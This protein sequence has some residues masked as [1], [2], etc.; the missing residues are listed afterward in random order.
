MD[1]S[2]K[3]PSPTMGQADDEK[4]SR[5]DG[6]ITAPSLVSNEKCSEEEV[7]IDPDPQ[8]TRHIFDKQKVCKY[9]HN[10]A[11]VTMVT[12]KKWGFVKKRKCFGWITTKVEKLS[13][14]SRILQRSS[15]LPPNNARTGGLSDDKVSGGENIVDNSDARGL[16]IF[17]RNDGSNLKDQ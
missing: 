13:C 14:T 1:G 6:K 5:G 15:L 2:S 7:P 8:N 3:I 17:D 4:D 11:K 9:H 12:S 10:R 16:V